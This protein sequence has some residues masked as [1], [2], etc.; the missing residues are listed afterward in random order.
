LELVLQQS[1]CFGAVVDLI[2]SKGKSG[3]EIG[4]EGWIFAR[5]GGGSGGT[6]GHG[7]SPAR[8]RTARDEVPQFS[9]L[10]WILS[11]NNSLWCSFFTTNQCFFG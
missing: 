7:G 5:N 8:T 6:S 3:R 11:C 2:G 9:C 4:G 1:E 10:I